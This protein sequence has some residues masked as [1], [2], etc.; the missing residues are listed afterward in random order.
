M[1]S[2][3]IKKVFLNKKK[4]LVTFI[5]GGDPNM[6]ISEKILFSLAENGA[7]IIEIG[8]PF[9]DPMADGPTIQLASNRAIQNNVNLDNIFLMCKNF[10]KKNND[11][12]I[13]LMGYYNVIL[14]YG[15]QKFTKSC[16]KNEVDGLIIVDLQPDEDEELYN[17][18]RFKKLDLIRLITP[19][20]NPTR[21]SKILKQ[22][23]GFL[24]YVAVAGITG[25]NSANINK[26]KKS[27]KIIKSKTKL[28][29]VIGFGIKNV[30]QAKEI[31][32]IADGAVIGS[33]IIK[34]IEKNLNSS[35]KIL[36]QISNFI[37]KLK[38]GI[39]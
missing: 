24:Y 3:R 35:K 33:A 18:I 38:K 10:R 21:L 7:D 6:K 25:Q 4:K 15:I 9:S 13:I 31:C 11:I 34:I 12:P 30:R 14:H 26:L 39:S 16:E 27:L 2:P 8:M 19:T 36:L 29:I 28:P 23:S 20:T 37:K 22:A 17:S 1:T 32:Q 5:T